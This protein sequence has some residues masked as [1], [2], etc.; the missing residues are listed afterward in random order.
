MRTGLF[1]T[2]A[3]V[4]AL[5]LSLQGFAVQAATIK[6]LAG[7]VMTPVVGELGRQFERATGHKLLIQ[8]GSAPAMQRRIGAGE[9]FDVVLL[10]TGP[11]DDLAKQEKVAT[12]TRRDVARLG[13]ALAGR[14]G[15]PKP[16][17][18]SVDAFKRAL[19]NAKSIAYAPDT[20][21]G[22]HLVKIFERLGIAE[23]ITV[24]TRT[25]VDVL[26]S[27]QAVA[28][29]EVEFVFALSSNFLS[30]PGVESVG[31][32]PPELQNY[33][34]FQAGVSAAAKEPEAARAFIEFLTAPEA[35]GVIKANGMEPGTIP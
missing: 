2:A 35:E 14:V 25:Y 11:M 20:T 8:Y 5:A 4:A 17:M 12:A 13:M 18:N 21:S 19:V 26:P 3:S 28:N 1:A 16:E 15:A 29:G 33:L 10:S 22:I 32:L 9:L 7:T 30:V 34:V 24:K 6:V 31:A 23:Q 27:V